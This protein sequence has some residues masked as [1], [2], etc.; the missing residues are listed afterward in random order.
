MLEPG[1][2]TVELWSPK[3]KEISVERIGS[4]L[5]RG[6]NMIK[7]VFIEQASYQ[8]SSALTGGDVGTAITH[9][10]SM[11]SVPVGAYGVNGLVG[12]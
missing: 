8:V 12:R 10:D 11:Q 5:Y 4:E 7:P 1:N 2:D 6:Q 9:Y 3:I